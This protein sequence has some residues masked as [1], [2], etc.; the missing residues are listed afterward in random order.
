MHSLLVS[1]MMEMFCVVRGPGHD[2]DNVARK[3][4]KFLSTNG[5]IVSTFGNPKPPERY[6]LTEQFF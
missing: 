1:Y 2:K 4:V 6:F 3:Y 5:S